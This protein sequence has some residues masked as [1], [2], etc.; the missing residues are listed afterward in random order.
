MNA[1]LKKIIHSGT[2]SFRFH[3]AILG[4]GI[5]VFFMLLAVQVHFN[6]QYLLHG[7]ANNNAADEFLVISKPVKVGVAKSASAF[8][9]ADIRLLQNQPFAH[10]VAALSSSNFSVT[11]SS[12]SNA[13]PFYTD[14]YFESV[15]DAFIDVANQQWKWSPGQ[16]DL[17]VIIPAFFIDLYNTGMAMSQESLPQLSVEALASIPLKVTIKGELGTFELVGHVV[18]VSDR[19]NA[20]LV[21]QPFMEWANKQ[22]GYATSRPPAR[23]V[24]RTEDPSSPAIT[25]FLAKQG[26]QTNMEKARFSK[27]RGI[28]Q[29]VLV[30]VGGIGGLLLLFGL[31]VF[32][33]FIEVAIAA[34]RQDIELL[35]TI[36]LAPSRIRHFIQYTFAPAQLMSILLGLVL[37]SI[38]QFS[39]AYFLADKNIL[40]PAVI[41]WQTLLCAAIV[42]LMQ[43][44]VLKRSIRV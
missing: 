42:I 2:G 9:P 1:L 14:A 7:K 28:V 40:L 26:W 35:Q 43:W 29:I 12:Y 11:I 3:M 32:S 33:L 6:F 22:Y 17:P 18:G 4:T 10:E 13:L 30:I 25:Q 21:P 34:C 31:L 36:G 37:L 24:L 15:P 8:T 44:W 27:L 19:L 5:A 38:T 20:I 41:S 16:N 39:L 23:L